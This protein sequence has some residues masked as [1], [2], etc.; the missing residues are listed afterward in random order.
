MSISS[1]P[2]PLPNCHK[3][4]GGYNPT[5]AYLLGCSVYEMIQRKLVQAATKGSPIDLRCDKS[6]ELGL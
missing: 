5:P 4:G 1:T 2:Y 3:R 6:M